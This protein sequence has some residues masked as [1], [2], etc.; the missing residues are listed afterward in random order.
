MDFFYYVISRQDIIIYVQ[1]FKRHRKILEIDF[2][3]K[4]L[5]IIY[6]MYLLFEEKC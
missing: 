4:F 2:L 1:F 5:Y 6:M 3:Y